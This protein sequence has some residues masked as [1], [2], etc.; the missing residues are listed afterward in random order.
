MSSHSD[1]QNTLVQ[2][3]ELEPL[4]L[5]VSRKLKYLVPL[6]PSATRTE[7]SC[8]R[9]MGV[10]AGSGSIQITKKANSRIH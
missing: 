8:S 1:C 5:R 3:L 7:R 2:D 10:G 9:R 6:L 4:E